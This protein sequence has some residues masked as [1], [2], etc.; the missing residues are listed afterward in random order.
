MYCIQSVLRQESL[1][2]LA[3]C[4]HR[5][6]IDRDKSLV[7]GSSQRGVVSNYYSRYN[8]CNILKSL[9]TDNI[10]FSETFLSDPPSSC[11]DRFSALT[12]SIC[13]HCLLTTFLSSRGNGRER[14]EGGG[15]Q[16]IIRLLRENAK[17]QR[18][19]KIWPPQK[20]SQT[21][22]DKNWFNTSA[23]AHF[24]KFY[25]FF[26]VCCYRWLS[27]FFFLV[28]AR[29][30]VAKQADQ[31]IVSP[32]VVPDTLPTSVYGTEMKSFLKS[33]KLVLVSWNFQ[34]WC[35]SVILRF[36]SNYIVGQKKSHSRRK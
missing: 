4:E 10:I 24:R 34:G 27:N 2:L 3:I 25:H 21:T 6:L 32:P 1:Y 7:S 11:D 8:L 33:R 20:N 16:A 35:S 36:A 9:A 17:K 19:T 29:A 13:A 15:G 28:R 14:G 30:S 31:P 18:Q 23:G 5:L 26:M 12:I 22:Q